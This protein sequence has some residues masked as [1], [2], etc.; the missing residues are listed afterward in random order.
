[1]SIGVHCDECGKTYQVPDK[2]AG[3]RGKCPNG[4]PV[5]VPVPSEPADDDN[6]FAFTTDTTPEPLP[7]PTPK[8]GKRPRAAAPVPET[9][10]VAP[11]DDFAFPTQVAGA[12]SN[13]EDEEAP[14]PKTGRHKAPAKAGKGATGKPSLMPLILGGIM[15]V[16]G[17]GLGGTMFV[18]ARSQ[19][20]PLKE[21]AEA[22]DKKAAAA[23]QRARD[24]ESAKLMAEGELDRIKKN[25]IKD[26]A[27]EKQLSE[28]KKK[29]AEAEKRAAATP[30]EATGAAVA[31]AGGD[32]AMPAA[33]KDLDPN[34]PG[35]KNDPVMPGGRLANDPAK[36][37]R[38]MEKPAAKGKDK[39]MEK[40]AADADGDDGIP[41]GGKNWTVPTSIQVGPN[42]LKAGDIFWVRPQAD[43]AP[44]VE[45]GTMFVRFK[46]KLRKGKELPAKVAATIIVQTGNQL[47][48][49]AAPI[50]LNGDSGEM[51]VGYDAKEFKGSLPV[52]FFIGEQTAKNP[53]VYS[54]MIAFQVDFGE[55]KK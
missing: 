5:V 3:R 39:E 49:A 54:S 11:G 38:E 47:R 45:D 43:V 7:A 26:P 33:P 10:E 50:T 36:K 9:V 34:A 4:H 31:G 30:K 48:T 8:T 28:A 19:S 22:A 21:Q 15:A 44:K 20:G 42:L 46:W 35:G 37:G 16:V 18:M 51:Q 29:L 14:R 32:A 27:L 6:A 55:G 13:E 24:A 52:T 12:T 53:K 1:M 41:L 40:P 25:P 17:L 2:M 23:E